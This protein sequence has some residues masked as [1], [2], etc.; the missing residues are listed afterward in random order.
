[1]GTQ[2]YL[3]QRN[4]GSGDVL[5]SLMLAWMLVLVALASMSFALTP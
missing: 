1:M 4:S 5:K 3:E 2:G